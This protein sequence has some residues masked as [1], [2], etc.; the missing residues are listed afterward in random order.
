VSVRFLVFEI[1]DRVTGWG[2]LIADSD[3]EWL[4][5]ARVHTLEYPDPARRSS[6]SIRLIGADV[7]ALPTRFG[8]GNTIPGFATITGIWL[9]DAIEVLSQSPAG[10][11]A[12]ARPQ[13]TTPPCPAPPGGWPRG[14]T[15]DNLDFDLGNLQSRGAAVTAV[16]FRPSSEQTV[17]VVAAS[18]ID[19]VTAVLQPQL[20]GRLCIVPSRWTRAQL[21][22]VHARFTEH[23]Q[24][25]ALDTCG[26][27]A[28][29]HAQAFIVVELLRV[30]AELADWA[31]TLPDGL[32]T[33]R[34]SLT[35][36]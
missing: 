13:W 25:W 24:D 30:T 26:E 15:D 35:P 12:V 10:P 19:A 32:L 27:G 14:D 20:P 6:R 18:D 3:G 16:L 33:L 7:D 9:G 34:P 23:W 17:L 5:L 11:P 21:D 1:G 2:R 22:A 28:D 4:D 29:E 36:A 8:R 31:D